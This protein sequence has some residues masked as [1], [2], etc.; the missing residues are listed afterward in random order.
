MN[1]MIKRL[2]KLILF[3]VFFV[4]LLTLL[5]Y[6]VVRISFFLIAD[7]FWYEKIL[8]FLMLFAEI[9]ILVHSLGYFINVFISKKRLSN[10][11]LDSSQKP[12][13]SSYPPVAIIVASYKEPLPILRDTLTC[14]YNISY[15]NKHLYFLDDTRYDIPWENPEDAQEYRKSIEE[16][17]QWFDVNLFRSKWHGAKAGKINDFLAYL[18][19][20]RKEEFEVIINEKHKKTEKEK[21]LIIFD[22]DMN[23]I[24]NFVEDLVARMEANAKLA[25]IQTPQYYT[26]FLTNRV[27][28]ASG[29]L[30][31][32]FY[33]Y[34]CE[35]K[36]LKNT[37]F[38][39]GTNVLFRIEALMSVG[40]FDESS[41]TEDFATS[42]KLHGQGWESQYVNKV[43][44]FGQGPNDLGGYF[45]Q[46]FRWAKGTIGILKELPIKMWENIHQFNFNQWWEY[47]L[48]STH[49]L[50]GWVFFIMF[51]SPILFLLF[52][53]PSYF[54]YPEIYFISYLPYVGLSFLLFFSTIMQRKYTGKDLMSALLLSA[55]SFPV[56]MK[57]A[58]Y[59]LFGIK[60]KFGITPKEGVHVL[61]LRNLLPNLFISLLCIF[62]VVW[63]ILRLYYERDPFYAFAVN[64]FWTL[65]NFITFS[66]FLYFNHPEEEKAS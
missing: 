41:I 23:P 32:V 6:L 60:S 10:S 27:A 4:F 20:H 29:I 37:M 28:R 45:K 40:G 48:A 9:F 22:A 54:I 5:V 65:Y 47:F 12:V 14:F 34:I 17:C 25:F 21:Y 8:A 33:E 38:C 11:E 44:A 16:L 2:S 63:G 57:A 56:F 59:A 64:I 61:S 35:G 39:C 51:I 3:G 53:V 13:L 30:Q 55:V 42:L 31:A 52:D 62:G 19:G 36:S 49:Y 50:V 18:E 58:F 46:Q 7:Y 24:P 26:N 43:L 1:A 15:P 66:F